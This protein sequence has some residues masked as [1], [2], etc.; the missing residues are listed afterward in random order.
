MKFNDITI[1]QYQQIQAAI[2]LN[3]DNE[4]AQWYS[5]LPLF[6]DKTVEDYKKMKYLDFQKVVQDYRFLLDGQLPEEWVKSFT[7]KGETFYVTQFVTDWSTEQ[8]ISM[9]NLTRE[10]DEIINNIH[11][12]IAILTYKKKDEVLTLTELERRGK[13]FQD[14]LPI[15]TAYPIGFFFAVLLSKLSINTQFYLRAKKGQLKTK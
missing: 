8:F 11:T 12:I 10:R 5:I 7:V 6:T 2:L 13:L 14:H 9:G 3:R 1:F 4:I 15:V